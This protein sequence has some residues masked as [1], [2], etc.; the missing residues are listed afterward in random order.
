MLEINGLAYI[1]TP[2]KTKGGGAAIV[3]NLENYS[4]KKLEIII[5][6]NMDV[7]WALLKPKYLKPRYKQI[8]V[9]SFYSPPK[10]QRNSKMA[11]HLVGTLHMLNTNY[12]DSGIIMG[13]DINSMD[14][15]P[16]LNCGLRLKNIVDQPTI[17]GRI[18][19]VII[20]NLN[21]FYN[22]PIITPPL[23]PDDPASAK[24][25]DHHIPVSY[26]HTDHHNPPQRRWRIHTYRPLP[27]SR[28]RKFGNWITGEEWELLSS[29]LPASELTLQFEKILRDNLDRYCPTKT[30]KLGPQDK[31]FI[32][33]EL[34]RIHRLKSREYCKKGKSLK[35][36]ALSKEFATKF[37][38]EAEKYLY[39]NVEALMN[40]K[41]GR[42]YSTLKKLGAQPGDCTDANTFT[43]PCHLS[44]NLTPQQSA[45]RIAAHFADISG[46]FPALSTE[47]LPGRVQMKLKYDMRQPPTVS[48]EDTW[49]KI[50]AAKKPQSGVPDDLPK[51]L[52]KE[53]SVELATP[54][55][56]IINKIVQSCTWPDHWKRE[57]ITPIAKIPEPQT[58]DDLRP[59]SLTP[60][61]SKV[62][63]HFVVK[64]LLEFIEHKIDIRQYG[65]L[66]ANSITHYTL[67]FFRRI[68]F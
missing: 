4:I 17:N 2:R 16:I 12:P 48:V 59:I 15:R 9:C 55:Q 1:S 33:S 25:S 67:I 47:L 7:V 43:L 63:E 18:Y 10:C 50:R 56:R 20:T 19:D 21:M 60:F 53:F 30:I 26:P 22:C 46:Q 38:I 61:F 42:A 5:P 57:Y 24:P 14:I 35:Y 64:W 29:D 34:K 52:T 65:G 40:T 68:F 28:I 49:Q 41:P 31:A 66:K 32:T 3:A 6:S 11:D 27:D 8:I 51:Q 45:E 44:D 39:K 37:R 54:L 62:T 36:K 13:A 23:Q 58:E